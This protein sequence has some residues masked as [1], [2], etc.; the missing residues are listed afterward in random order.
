LLLVGLLVVSFLL[1]NGLFDAFEYIAM[2]IGALFMVAQI[3]ILIDFAY[4]WNE[5]WLTEP[6]D[7]KVGVL[8]CALLG[9]I[10]ALVAMILMFLYLANGPQCSLEQGF[11]GI[12]I[13]ITLLFSILSTLRRIE[14]GAILPSSVCTVYCYWVLYSALSD[15]PNDTC[16]MTMGK[17]DFRTTLGFLFGAVSVAYAAFN[18]SQN[19]DALSLSVKGGPKRSSGDHGAP[20]KYTPT[21]EEG[22]H[23]EE[24]TE[25]RPE[26]DERALKE[27]TKMAWRFQLMLMGGA[28]YACMLLT[29][30][31]EASA[32]HATPG[33]TSVWIQI[34]SQ[35]LAA[36][37]YT[38]SLLAPYVLTT[39]E[40]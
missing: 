14:H 32:S 33:M 16:N 35:W 8:A 10:I 22:T 38:W 1:P 12:T 40:F 9:Y 37:L 17:S 11:I 6:K 29:D 36:L 18:A 19:A 15:N 30:W 25:E 2:V 28:C 3:I 27:E 31:G 24:T 13:T 34:A 5:N 23:D 7:W 20:I 26:E 39:R 4:A 21:S